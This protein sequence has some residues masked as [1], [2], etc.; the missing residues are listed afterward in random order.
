[1]LKK[2]NHF[3][4]L[5]PKIRLQTYVISDV[6]ECKEGDTIIAKDSFASYLYVILRGAVAKLT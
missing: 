1:M 6:V 4:I 2:L 3:R 5:L